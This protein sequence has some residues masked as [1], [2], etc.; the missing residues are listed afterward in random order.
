MGSG[1]FPLSRE[2]KDAGK[3]LQ[4]SK[5]IDEVIKSLWGDVYSGDVGG[6]QYDNAASDGGSLALLGLASKLV[7]DQVREK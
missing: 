2:D 7:L 5:L 4:A 6:M 1:C 3:L